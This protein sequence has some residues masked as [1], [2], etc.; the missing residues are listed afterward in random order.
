MKQDSQNGMKQV[1]VNADQIAVFV[2]INNVCN[3]KL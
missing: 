2:I 1:S 3:N